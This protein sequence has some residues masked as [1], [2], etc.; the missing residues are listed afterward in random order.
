M[1]SI[2]TE[3]TCQW[4]APVQNRT[5]FRLSFDIFDYFSFG[6][7]DFLFVFRS[8]DFVDRSSFPAKQT[9]HE[10]TRSNTK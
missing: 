3:N 5:I 6:I 4:S 2:P 10:V 9:I 7:V 1:L 8:C